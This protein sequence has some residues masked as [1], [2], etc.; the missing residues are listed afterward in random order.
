MRRCGG[1]ELLRNRDGGFI[2]HQHV[3]VQC[4]E[5]GKRLAPRFRH[6]GVDRE[7]LTG[8]LGL[9]QQQVQDASERFRRRRL[10]A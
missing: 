10:L 8:Q 1:I 7:L 3:R 2:G 5:I 6:T 9:Q 4:S